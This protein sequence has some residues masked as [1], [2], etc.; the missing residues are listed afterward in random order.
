[1]TMAEIYRSIEYRGLDWS[2]DFLSSYS[3]DAQWMSTQLNLLLTSTSQPHLNLEE[4][5]PITLRQYIQDYLSKHRPPPFD[6][7]QS[8]S[9]HLHHR[10]LADLKAWATIFHTRLVFTPPE[11]VKSFQSIDLVRWT[12]YL[13]LQLLVN[14]EDQHLRIAGLSEILAEGPL[15]FK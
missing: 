12:T 2:L 5:S 14:I 11:L 7:H 3:D 9:G 6:L 1:M 4:Q 8:S 13:A 10:F 15:N